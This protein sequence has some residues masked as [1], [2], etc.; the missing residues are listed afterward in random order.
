MSFLKLCENI[1]DSHTDINKHYDLLDIIFL[2]LF[3]LFALFTLFA[4]LSGA[5]GW[6]TIHIFG[7]AQ[8]EWLREYLEFPNGIPT[9]HSTGQIIRGVKAESLLECCEQWVNTI[10]I[11]GEREQIAFDGKVIRVSGNGTSISPQQLMSA[12]V[13]DSGLILYQQEVSDKT[14]EVPVMQS[15]LRQLS[16]KGAIITADTMY[17]QTHMA[18]MIRAEDADYMLQVKDNQRHLCKEITVFFH[19][20]YRDSPEVLAKRH[21]EEIEK[22]HG[23]INERNYRLLPITYRLAGMTHWKDIQSVVEVTRKRTFKKKGKEQIEQ[24]VSYYITSLGDDVKEA[25]RAIR[26]NWAIETSQHWLLD[27]AFREDESQI[28]AEDEAKNMALFRRPLPNLIK[29]HP[30]KDSVAGK[31]MR[32]GWGSQFRAEILFGQKPTK[33]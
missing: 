8:L 15:M 14:N 7:V 2:A 30:L 11:K 10:R 24:E 17:C 25:A 20:T 9:R 22:A 33:V 16:V 21:F 19:K 12:M 31:M 27:V 32:A 28:Y 1:E 13:V 29:A 5:K 18:E 26:N 6:K 23:R 3:A 4:V